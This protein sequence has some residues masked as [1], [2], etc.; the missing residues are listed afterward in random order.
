[1]RGTASL[2]EEHE[3]ILMILDAAD[4]VARKIER[5]EQVHPETLTG[6]YEF[7]RLFTDRCHHRKEEELFFPLLRKK[8]APD[9]SERIEAMLA[10]H[11]R[12]RLLV[13]AMREAA[14]GY[15][16]GAEGAGRQ[17]AKFAQT[18][19]AMLRQHIH[20][21][22]YVLFRIADSLF[23][24]VDQCE[25]QA[26]F[27]RLEGEKM[28]PAVGERLDV[29]MARLIGGPFS[30]CNGSS[31]PGERRHYKRHSLA[32]RAL[33]RTASALEGSGEPVNI[34]VAGLLVRTDVVPAEGTSLWVHFTI[35]GPPGEFIASGRVVHSQPHLLGLVFL[36]EPAGLRRLLESVESAA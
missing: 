9:V 19:S 29:L 6:L 15:R 28:G 8:G 30:Y 35:A 4:E 13:Q 17:W 5:G 3:T 34:A 12:G 24:D 11:D 21:E 32:G 2:R 22:N 20:K 26:A 23:T 36:E 16:E 1:M 7:F 25:L 31:V 18:Y 10:E 33:F 14:H 27:E